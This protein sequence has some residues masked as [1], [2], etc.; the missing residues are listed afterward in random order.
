MTLYSALK[1]S[2]SYIVEGALELFSPDHDNYPPLI[3]AQSYSGDI[4]SHKQRNKSHD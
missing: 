1:D 2:I 3:G 4:Y